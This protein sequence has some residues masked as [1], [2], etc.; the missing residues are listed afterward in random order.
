ML[1]LSVFFK[2]VENRQAS[3]P[4][5]QLKR[6]LD[7]RKQLEAEKKLLFQTIDSASAFKQ[8]LTRLLAK[9]LREHELLIANEKGIAQVDSHVDDKSIETSSRVPY[10]LAQSIYDAHSALQEGLVDSAERTF[11]D[12][13]RISGD[14]NDQVAAVAGLSE[15][16]VAQGDMRIARELIDKALDLSLMNDADPESRARLYVQQGTLELRRGNWEIAIT[17]FQQAERLALSINSPIVA[18]FALAWRS[19]GHAFTHDFLPAIQAIRNAVDL[20]APGDEEQRSVIKSLQVE[21]ALF[22]FSIGNMKPVNQLLFDLEGDRD[23][24][25]DLQFSPAW[26]RLRAWCAWQN[27]EKIA[28]EGFFRDA[29]ALAEQRF[30][31]RLQTELLPYLEDMAIFFMQLGRDRESEHYA[32][33]VIEVGRGGLQSS[34]PLAGAHSI[35]L[36]FLYVNRGGF[37]QAEELARGAIE[38]FK[39]LAMHETPRAATALFLLALVYAGTQRQKQAIE[40]LSEAQ[41]LLAAFDQRLMPTARAI[42]R[43]QKALSEGRSLDRINGRWK[44]LPVGPQTFSQY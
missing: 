3:D 24:P 12:V 17:S 11:S 40:L 29:L 5:A 35:S 1:E 42:A 26:P 14:L 4:G 34:S 15:V 7:F 36:G 37:A 32:N 6:V 25:I 27:G 9:W 39:R 28:A 38:G 33:R 20:R 16:K 30:S 43:C 44:L 18:A 8:S 21:G 23:T 31:A 41:T 19:I 2:L 10:L 13:L 22:H